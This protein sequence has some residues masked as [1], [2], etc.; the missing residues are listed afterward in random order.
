[1]APSTAL[2]QDLCDW[3]ANV[4]PERESLLLHEERTR[5]MAE[6]TLADMFGAE[7]ELIFDKYD[8]LI[9]A[10]KGTKGLA[11]IQGTTGIR[12]IPA[13]ALITISLNN[14]VAL[15]NLPFKF[16]WS[17]VALS[18]KTSDLFMAF[19]AWTVQEREEWLSLTPGVRA[20]RCTAW[21]TPILQSS[22]TIRVPYV[23]IET[24]TLD[25]SGCPQIPSFDLTWASECVG[26]DG[27]LFNGEL[28]LRTTQNVTS[29][30]QCRT[31]QDLY[32]VL[33][34]FFIMPRTRETWHALRIKVLK[35]IQDNRRSTTKNTRIFWARVQAKLAGPETIPAMVEKLQDG[36][37]DCETE[38]VDDR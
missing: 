7:P 23:R 18:A 30:G 21:E 26:A 34:E 24:A 6:H 12:T 2:E 22:K 9:Q 20:R 14:H 5:D 16:C 31:S 19:G 8:N 25:R 28:F 11:A 29:R 27:T 15:H 10:L 17:H 32:K 13:I 37:L 35:A 1:M 38:M 4:D 33:T 36:V 3:H